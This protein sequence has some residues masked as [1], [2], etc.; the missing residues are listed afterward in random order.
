[1]NTENYVYSFI[2]LNHLAD[3]SKLYEKR[4]FSGR[5]ILRSGVD[6]QDRT[7]GS[8][9]AERDDGQSVRVTSTGSP[10]RLHHTEGQGDLAGNISWQPKKIRYG[11]D[12]WV[13]KRGSG[14]L[15]TYEMLREAAA[16]LFSKFSTAP[17]PLKKFKT[18]YSSRPETVPW[19]YFS[20]KM[21]TN[22][23]KI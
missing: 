23:I 2:G 15:V 16:F 21:D 12:H 6:W 5:G 11:G 22:V 9:S 13:R 4:M 7:C 3:K 20:R 19:G 14:T 10:Q 17:S 18:T 1:M 8:P